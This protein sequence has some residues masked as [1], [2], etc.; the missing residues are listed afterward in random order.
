MSPSIVQHEKIQSPYQKP[1]LTIHGIGVEYPPDKIRPEHLATLARRFHPSSPALDKVLMINEFTGIETRSAIGTIDHPIANKP[2][3]PTIAELC[4]VFLEYGV[5]LSVAACRKALEQWGGDLADITHV[6][7]TTCTNSAN[8]GY[9]H[10][11]VKQL[12][13]STSI[14]KVL[15]HGVGCSGGLAALRT[16]ANIALGHSFRRRPA[17]ILV[18]ACEISSVLVRSELES[19]DQDQE[20]R[21]G[22]TLFSD[23]ASAVV[24]SNGIGDSFHDEPLLELLGWEHRIIDDTESD[25]GF[26]V[27][28]LGWKVVLTQRVPKLACAAVPSIFKELVTSIPELADADLV[29]AAQFDWALHPGGSTIITGVEQTMGLTVEHLRA[30]YEIY[31]N[32]GNS[33]SA[34]V[35]SVM[36]KLL[37]GGPGKDYVISCAFGPGIAVEMMAFKRYG[38]SRSGTESPMQ[39]EDVD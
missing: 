33:S 31:V 16:A 28:P 1:N 14:E 5:K 39:P 8:P 27:H 24:L 11:V 35:F 17:R 37:K 10:Y 30:S 7:S 6:V 25:L 20:V 19:I 36:S 29:E 32:H 26:D 18:L 4:D 3:P 38:A 9:D 2:D 22:V 34:T 21:I 15:L 12:G 23:C 13:L